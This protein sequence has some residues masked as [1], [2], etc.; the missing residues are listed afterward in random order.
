MNRIAHTNRIDHVHRSATGS[1]AP[2]SVIIHDRIESAFG[3]RVM[4]ELCLFGNCQLLLMQHPGINSLIFEN[5]NNLV[6]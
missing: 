6:N 2:G 5:N 1:F 3:E 4:L